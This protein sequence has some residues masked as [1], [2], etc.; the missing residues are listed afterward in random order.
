MCWGR[1]RSRLLRG[2][3]NF[4]GRLWLLRGFSNFIGRSRLLGGFRNFL[5]RKG[6]QFL[7]RKGL[8]FLVGKGPQRFLVRK[9][10]QRF[11]VR[12][13]LQF[14]PIVRK[15]L[16]PYQ[17]LQFLIQL[18]WRRGHRKSLLRVWRWRWTRVCGWTGVNGW[19]RVCRWTG[20]N[21]WTGAW[22]WM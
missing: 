8:Q 9:G 22:T 16:K 6:L 13:G 21:G 2:F 11:L 7:V 14:L 10:L 20:V 17:G 5:V 15:E 4:V 19:T 1:I 3:S 18:K 12:K